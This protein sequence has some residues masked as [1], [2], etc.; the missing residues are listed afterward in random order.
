M[1]LEITTSE[2]NIRFDRVWDIGPEELSK[3]LN[4]VLVIDVRLLEEISGDINAI[5]GAK[6]IPLI[7]LIDQTS[8]LPKDKPIVVTCRN[9]WRSAK[10]AAF[11]AQQGVNE[12]YNLKGGLLL[13]NEF[14]AKSFEMKNEE[15]LKG[16]LKGCELKST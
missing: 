12:V 2:R 5:P 7:D 10:A 1:S 9:G 8:N 3:I 15:E 6:A 4:K 16:E 11:L 13:W 14:A